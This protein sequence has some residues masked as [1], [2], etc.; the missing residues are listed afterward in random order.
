M[1]S[2]F[3]EIHLGQL[4]SDIRDNF[5]FLPMGNFMKYC[6]PNGLYTVSWL[7]IVDALVVKKKLLWMLSIPAVCMACEI[8]QAFD[9][10]PGT[11]DLG[12]LACIAL[13]M[14]VYVIYVK[15]CYIHEKHS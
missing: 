11:F 3:D 12:D 10:T 13:P 14:M 7:L 2:W 8:L 5:G 6:L 1:F 4:V 15:I 9:I